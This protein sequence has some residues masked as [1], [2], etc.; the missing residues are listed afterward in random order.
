MTHSLTLQHG[1][2]R[3]ERIENTIRDGGSTALYAT[4]QC[5]VDAV[6]TVHRAGQGETVDMVYT[7][8]MVDTVDTVFTIQTALHSLNNSVYAYKCC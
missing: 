1:S 8:D 5:T 2:K 3:C 6:D 4:L 7:V